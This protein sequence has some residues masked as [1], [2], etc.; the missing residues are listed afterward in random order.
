MQ[1]PH[2]TS[3]LLYGAAVAILLLW[4]WSL[5]NHHKIGVIVRVLVVG[6]LAVAV[7]RFV[8]DQSGS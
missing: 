7:L 4:V 6:F 3:N 8:R 1:L 2:L 5:A